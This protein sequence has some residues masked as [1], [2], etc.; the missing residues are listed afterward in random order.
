MMILATNAWAHISD[1]LSLIVIFAA[2]PTL[3]VWICLKARNQMF[4]KKIQMAKMAIEKD[5]SLNLQEFLT[6]STP[7]KKTYAEKS[8]S[9][10]LVSSILLFL[11]LGATTLALVFHS[12]DIEDG[13]AFFGIAACVLLGIGLAFLVSFFYVKKLIR[14]G[15]LK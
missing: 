7:K 8:I 3:I 1:A 5:P 10:V 12:Q 6:K 9:Y 15:I 2:M 13:F 14:K 4:D 11:G